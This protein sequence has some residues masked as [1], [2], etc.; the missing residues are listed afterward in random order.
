VVTAHGDP[1][2]AEALAERVS[3]SL[4]VDANHP[5]AAKVTPP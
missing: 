2:A 1:S 4:A 3:S 5:A